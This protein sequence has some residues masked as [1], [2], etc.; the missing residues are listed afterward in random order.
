MLGDDLLLGQIFQVAAVL[1]RF[2]WDLLPDELSPDVLVELDEPAQEQ[3]LETLSEG[4]IGRIVDELDSDD[5]ADVVGALDEEKAQKVLETLDLE[6]QRDVR[7]LLTYDEETAGGL[8]AL[9][10]ASV[11]E[12]ETVGQA[13]QTL[14]DLGEKEG[15]E[16]IYNV[17]VISEEGIL[18]G[19]LKLA[20]LIL[21]RP[22]TPVRKL[23]NPDVISVPTAMD[24]E[25]VASIVQKYDLVS[26]PVVDDFGRL[27]GRITVDD[28]MDVLT[29][30][31]EEDLSIIAGTGDEEPGERSTFKI[32]RERAPWL[33]T[34]LVG[35][36]IAATVMHHFKSTLLHVIALAFFVPVI[37]A[38]GGS[39]AIQSAS[40]VVRGLATGEI[41]LRDLV[42]RILKEIR[43][44]LI[45]GIMLGL[46][47]G[48]IVSIWLGEPELG[49]LIGFILLIN[50]IIASLLGAS[51]P[52]IMKRLGIDPALAMGPFVTTFIDIIGLI[53]YLGLAMIFLT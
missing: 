15:I 24:Q 19:W 10:V 8:M 49:F 21:A 34:G 48:L 38:M 47:L 36:L 29:E 13:I 39:T 28:V 25:D 9:E 42:P 12:T 3:L 1:Q 35:G 23:M 5:A 7:R 43:V 14:R 50:I 37:T 11:K 20:Q 45:N 40:I 4:E 27:V 46:L 6:S 51:V 16:D 18:L 26:L 22:E 17:Y 32:S 53:I 30:E 31:A 2:V 44:A 52:M 41:A 33:L